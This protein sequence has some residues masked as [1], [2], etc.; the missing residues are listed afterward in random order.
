[1]TTRIANSG[2]NPKKSDHDKQQVAEN[3]PGGFPGSMH[4]QAGNDGDRKSVPDEP[5][6]ANE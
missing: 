2:K 5:K 6:T 1:M 4:K 3:E